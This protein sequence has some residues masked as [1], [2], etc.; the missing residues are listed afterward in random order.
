ME[1]RLRSSSNS[2]SCIGKKS[3]YNWIRIRRTGCGIDPEKT[4]KVDEYMKTNF[5][6]IYACGDVAGPYNFTHTAA[7]QAWYCA[8]N[9]MFKGPF[10]GFKVDYRLFPG[11]PLPTRR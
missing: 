3:E 11:R 1:I 4:I 2:L 10:Y 6:N 9:S 8:V 5:P 7:H